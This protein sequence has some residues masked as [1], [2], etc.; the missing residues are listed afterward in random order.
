MS[1]VSLASAAAGAPPI[2]LAP[3][4]RP[5]GAAG[6][7]LALHAAA[8]RAGFAAPRRPLP[9]PCPWPGGR[10]ATEW[11][12]TYRLRGAANTFQLHVSLQAASGRLLAQLRE[13]VEQDNDATSPPF[14]AGHA[15][16][17]VQAPRY[18]GRA[19]LGDDWEGALVGTDVLEAM[20]RQLLFDPVKAAA[21]KTRGG[22]LGG[23]KAV[24]AV[25]AAAAAAVAAVVVQKRR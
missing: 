1:L 25:L 19:A 5:D 22:R 24:A 4:L 23:G 20:A 17:G 16:M 6:V 14:I 7:A 8:L 11:V 3:S 21:A 18:V 12:W 9:S 10:T 13:I 2:L 15:Y